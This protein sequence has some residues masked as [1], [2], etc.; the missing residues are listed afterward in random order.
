MFD[1]SEIKEMY[2]TIYEEEPNVGDWIIMK[3]NYNETIITGEVRGLRHTKPQRGWREDADF[4]FVIWAGYKI[5]LAGVKGW[6]DGNDWE[7][8]S[9]MPEFENKKLT[10]RNREER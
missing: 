3:H 4:E 5:Q 7:I 10:K 6:L 9:T 8:L 2:E 1:D